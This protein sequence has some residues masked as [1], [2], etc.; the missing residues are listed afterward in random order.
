MD[1]RAAK[2]SQ[3]C[4]GGSSNV[5]RSEL[6]PQL[7]RWGLQDAGFDYDIVAVFGSQSTGKSMARM[8]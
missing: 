5:S 8:L 3:S 4:A 7:S 6:T 2:N 1:V